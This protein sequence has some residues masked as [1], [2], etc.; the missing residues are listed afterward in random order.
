ME[1]L[2]P[3]NMPVQRLKLAILPLDL[4]A[5]L[6]DYN[7]FRGNGNYWHVTQEEARRIIPSSSLDEVRL[8]CL[9]ASHEDTME[10][11]STYSSILF[12]L[13]SGWW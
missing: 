5:L 10:N 12:N 7:P 9:Y 13:D 1:E 11:G 4:F 8:T 6:C 2:P 3:Q